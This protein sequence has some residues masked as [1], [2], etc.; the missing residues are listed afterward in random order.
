MLGTHVLTSL[1]EPGMVTILTWWKDKMAVN[2]FFYGEAHQ[3]MI[4]RTYGNP[5]AEVEATQVSV[6]L[7]A[8]LP[9]GRRIGGG[10]TPEA[11]LNEIK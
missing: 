1:D 8:T 4:R 5:P 3:G 2:N 7:F 6:E 9:A 11:A 10:I